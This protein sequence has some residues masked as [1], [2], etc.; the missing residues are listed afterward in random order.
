MLRVTVQRNKERRDR[1]QPC[2]SNSKAKS[3]LLHHGVGSFVYEDGIPMWKCGK[4]PWVCVPGFLCNTPCHH[5][6][7]ECIFVI[8]M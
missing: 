2:Q 6:P 4:P 8:F 7:T 3:F 1:F 5:L